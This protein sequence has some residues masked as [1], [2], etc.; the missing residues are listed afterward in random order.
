[1]FIGI[2]ILNIIEIKYCK[3]LKIVCVNMNIGTKHFFCQLPSHPVPIAI[4]SRRLPIA[5]FYLLKN[6]PLPAD[7]PHCIARFFANNF[8]RLLQKYS[9]F[10]PCYL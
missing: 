7:V 6:T 2:I 10:G 9:P 4:G 5:N 8:S 3:R 1:M